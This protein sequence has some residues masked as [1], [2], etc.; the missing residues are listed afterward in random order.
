MHT[1]NSNWILKYQSVW[2]TIEKIKFANMI[3]GISLRK[4]INSSSHLRKKRI[5]SLNSVYISQYKFDENNFISL[6]EKDIFK[7]VNYELKEV[8]GNIYNYADMEKYII[9]NFRF[10]PEC[11]KVGYHSIFHQL[12]LFNK[13]I[14]HDIYLENECPICHKII[15]YNLRFDKTFGFVCECGY[16][17][18]ETNDFFKLLKKWNDELL[19]YEFNIDRKLSNFNNKYLFTSL[20][21]YLNKYIYKNLDYCL[22]DNIFIYRFLSDGLGNNYAYKFKP[23]YKHKVIYNSIDYTFMDQYIIILESI[24]KHFRKKIK[25]K[26]F[27]FYF[28]NYLFFNSEIKNS[29]LISDDKIKYKDIDEYLYAYIIWKKSVEGL[30]DYTEIHCINKNIRKE[31]ISNSLFYKYINY[32]LKNYILTLN[33]KND[34]DGFNDI[35]ILLSGLERIIG[36]ILISYFNCCL[37]F[38][39]RKKR[40]EPDDIIDFNCTI[41]IKFN[42]YLIYYDESNR[43]EY[44][45]K[46]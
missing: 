25:K 24:A 34:Y 33:N 15:P 27:K 26:N 7:K 18:L 4:Y 19:I 11:M 21:F 5:Y 23:I 44:I 41:N 22:I 9:S 30:D 42:K 2:C 40:F 32:E 6:C 39:R 38:I 14:I 37:E 46:D 1:W 29:Y 31:N 12:N 10:C 17:Y 8:L 20:E 28:L 16:N 13:C 45:I 36:D 43:V 35:G 3:D